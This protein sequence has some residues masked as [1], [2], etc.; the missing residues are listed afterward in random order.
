M[1]ELFGMVDEPI[2]DCFIGEL[3]LA[4]D[5]DSVP[6]GRVIVK[7]SKKIDRLRVNVIVEH[8]FNLEVVDRYLLRVD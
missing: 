8:L 5:Q 6:F 2:H 1:E 4:A 7:F 3:W